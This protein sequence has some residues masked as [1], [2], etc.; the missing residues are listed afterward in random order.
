MINTGQVPG[1]WA[2]RPTTAEAALKA[3]AR[4]ALVLYSDELAQAMRLYLVT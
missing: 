4:E 3:S 2:W 1:E